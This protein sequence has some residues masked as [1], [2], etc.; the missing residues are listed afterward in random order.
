MQVPWQ[1][2]MLCELCLSAFCAPT[3]VLFPWNTWRVNPVIWWFLL[4]P[5]TF[6]AR[7]IIYVYAE[8]GIAIITAS[9][10]FLF[11]PLGSS[12][13]LSFPLSVLLLC[14]SCRWGNS[15]SKISIWLATNCTINGKAIRP[16]ESLHWTSE[17]NKRQ[18]IAIN[19]YEGKFFLCHD[20]FPIKQNERK[21]IS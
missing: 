19:F 5:G 8:A 4:H 18:W 7:L 12:L 14:R 2:V 1:Y 20:V 6:N 10:C 9:I 17:C 15:L 3:T 11:F 21:K 16:K 13:F